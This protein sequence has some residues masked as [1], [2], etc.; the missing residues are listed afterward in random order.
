MPPITMQ[1]AL[2]TCDHRLSQAT[3]SS[4]MPISTARLLCKAS[5]RLMAPAGN[6]AKKR[7]E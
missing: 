3:L 5:P 2:T 1:A 7:P 6:K 4:L